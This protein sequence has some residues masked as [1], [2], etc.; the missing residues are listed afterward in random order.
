GQVRDD[1]RQRIVRSLWGRFFCALRRDM[2]R[3]GRP[4]LWRPGSDG[5]FQLVADPTARHLVRAVASLM[6]L[7]FVVGRLIG[8]H[9]ADLR[10]PSDS[11]SRNQRGSM[12]LP[13]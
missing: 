2:R 5:V 10:L 9:W 12:D 13:N 6:G 3:F 11:L 1:R 7:K 4:R 8:G